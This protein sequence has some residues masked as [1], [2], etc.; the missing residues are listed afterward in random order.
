MGMND[1]NQLKFLKEILLD[2]CN[3]DELCYE[4]L[5][6]IKEHIINTMEMVY[7]NVNYDL[8][9][10]NF[11]KLLKINFNYNH[12]YEGIVIYNQD[13]IIIP[14]EY[15]ELVD[16]VDFLAN[17]PQPEQRTEEWFDL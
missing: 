2:L 17:L 16:H 1:E 10:Y 3:N 15:K 9:D 13:E 7:D 4:N 12:D 6:H 14:D 11:Y 8:I 5:N